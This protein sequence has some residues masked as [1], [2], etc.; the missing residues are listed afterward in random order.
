MKFKK[1]TAFFLVLAFFTTPSKIYAYSNPAAVSLLTVSNFAALAHSAISAPLGLTVLNNG[2]LGVDNPGVCNGFPS[3]CTSSGTGI[4]NNGTIQFQNNVALQ[5]QTDATAITTDLGSRSVNQT[6]T[7]QLGGQTLT[8]G[9]YQVPSGIT[10]LTGD[11]TLNG[12]AD[13]VF[14]FHMTSTLITDTGSRIVLTG[15]V[16]PCH[17]FWKVDSSATFNDT[18]SFIGT[19]IAQASVTFA[20]GGATLNGRVIAQTGAITFNDTTI[21]NS[22]CTTTTPTATTT[23]TLTLNSSNS[24]SNSN[25][26]SIPYCP[27]INSQIVT[28]VIIKSERINPSSLFL[29]WGPYSGTE[30]FNVQYGTANGNW[31]YNTD[32]TGFSVILGDLP[33][34]QPIWARVAARNDCQIGTYG[35]SKLIGGP[36]LPK[37]G[38]PQ[39]NI[40]SRVLTNITQAIS[41]FFGSNNKK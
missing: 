37:T 14:I 1:F 41:G 34:N 29:N 40:F 21:N 8:Q 16:Q 2:N 33:S 23:P 32:V 20:G 10:N 13:S 35:E 4:I 31:L 18:T 5:G 11:L 19:V 36:G 6:L 3:P 39:A 15:G 27:P 24:N 22:Q 17:V 25:D 26:T 9:V 7:S 30:T 28:P 12:D 38:T